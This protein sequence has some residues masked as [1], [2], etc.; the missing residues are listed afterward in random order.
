MRIFLAMGLF[1]MVSVSASA[2]NWFDLGKSI[3]NNL[4]TY[5]DVDSL[6]PYSKRIPLQS[7]SSRYA[8]GFVQQTYINNHE[9]RNKGWYYSKD[10]YIVDCANNTYLSPS[11]ITYGF[12]NQVVN[13]Y[14]NKHFTANDFDMAFPET[15]GGAIVDIM[16]DYV[17][18]FYGSSY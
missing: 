5:I 7:S 2:A 16:C 4:Q 11:Y 3:D 18:A 6:Q 10:F 12:K 17:D 15:V 13:S 9:F 14:Q 1:S 8:S